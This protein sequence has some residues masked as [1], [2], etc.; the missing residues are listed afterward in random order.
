MAE[1]STL[2]GIFVPRVWAPDRERVDLVVAVGTP[3]TQGMA[4]LGAIP[5]TLGVDVASVFP[6]SLGATSVSGAVIETPARDAFSGEYRIHPMQR[7]ESGW[8]ESPISLPPGAHYGF[9][10]DGG[11]IHPDPRSRFQPEGVHSW[12]EVWVPPQLDHGDWAGMD[13]LGKV[14]YELHVGTFTPE[15]TFDAAAAKLRGLREIG[16]EVVEIMPVAAFEG[17]RGWG[18]DP[19]LLFATQAAYGGPGGLARFV[20][21]A[22]REG[23]A[24]CLDTVLNHLGNLGCYLAEYGPYFSPEPTIWG[25]GFDLSEADAPPL[26][27]HE[28]GETEA[29]RAE[30]TK[31]KPTPHEPGKTDTSDTEAADNKATPHATNATDR[32]ALAAPGEGFCYPRDAAWW[33]LKAFGIDALRL[34][35]I[36]AIPE[37]GRRRLLCAIRDGIP[38]LEA[39]SGWKRTLIAESDLNDWTLLETHGLDGLWNDDFHHAL[40]TLFTGE[41]GGYYRDFASREAL[42]K[43]LADTYFHNGTYSSFRGRMWG[44]TVPAELD[45]RHFVVCA[46]NHD[47]VGNRPFGDRPAAS[48]SEFSA[49][50]QLAVTLLTPY[51][52]LLFMGE[53]FGAITPFLFFADPIEP[54]DAARLREGRRAEFARAWETDAVAGGN[55]DLTHNLERASEPGSNRGSA[56]DTAAKNQGAA[57]AIPDPAAEVTFRDSH[58]DWAQSDSTRGQAFL[59]WTRELLALRTRRLHEVPSGIRPRARWERDC[60]VVESLGL[61]IQVNFG[62]PQPKPE[63]VLLDAAD[64]FAPPTLSPYPPTPPVPAPHTL[65]SS[66]PQTKQCRP[67]PSLSQPHPDTIPPAVSQLFICE[68]P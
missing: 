37:P 50:A 2:D 1:S 62:V 28:S 8:W 6:D 61:E 54:A 14:C 4:A 67:S 42:V 52:P 12:S 41:S 38:Q 39:E 31:P 40:H 30:A 48:L 60:L 57:P 11:K 59:R 68:Q 21:T 51:T 7:G 64:F 17:R 23:L 49:A 53:E 3:V 55:D 43:V 36:H 34:D 24:V 63:R 66:S 56:R 10:L 15:G 9:R 44:Q 5:S 25:Q 46:S 13:C 58:L 33:W 65:P 32:K 26:A 27:P 16:V 45:S 47:Q 22:H 18:Y 29:R 35:A 19:V 20:A